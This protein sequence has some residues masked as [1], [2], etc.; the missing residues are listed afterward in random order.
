MLRPIYFVANMSSEWMVRESRDRRSGGCIENALESVFGG[1]SLNCELLWGCTDL[2]KV[3]TCSQLWW[4]GS[5]ALSIWPRRHGRLAHG[6]AEQ[7]C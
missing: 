2:I 7:G 5:H 3:G 1:L 4:K 6:I